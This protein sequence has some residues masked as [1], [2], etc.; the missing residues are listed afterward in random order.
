MIII[1]A[2]KRRLSE[3]RC[4]LH[5]IQL[6]QK[7]PL[8]DHHCETCGQADR[9]IYRGECPRKDCCITAIFIN[10]KWTLEEKYKDV[11]TSKHPRRIAWG[12]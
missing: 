10:G 5:G 11:L 4:P 2:R 9:W 1:L 12:R 8:I 7:D 3:G 6:A